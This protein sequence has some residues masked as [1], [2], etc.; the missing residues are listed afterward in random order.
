[1][2]AV[3]V[4]SRL[5]EEVDDV[6]TPLDLGSYCFVILM[7]TFWSGSVCFLLCISLFFR[8]KFLKLGRAMFL[9]PEIG[10]SETPMFDEGIIFCCQLYFY[11]K[12]S[13]SRIA[14]TP[15]AADG[16]NDSFETVKPGLTRKHARTFWWWQVGLGG[17][18]YVQNLS[19][20]YSLSHGQSFVGQRFLQP[21]MDPDSNDAIFFII[22]LGCFQIMWQINLPTNES[23]FTACLIREWYFGFQ[24]MLQPALMSKHFMIK[25]AERKW[26]GCHAWG[27]THALHRAVTWPAQGTLIHTKTIMCISLEPEISIDRWFFQLDDSKSLWWKNGWKKTPLYIHLKLVVLFQGTRYT[28]ISQDIPIVMVSRC[29]KSLLRGTKCH[30]WHLAMLAQGSF[31]DQVTCA[32]LQ[33]GQSVQ[34]ILGINPIRD[35]F[36]SSEWRKILSSCKSFHQGLLQVIWSNIF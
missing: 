10:P 9:L 2:R 32:P 8:M 4:A 31:G 19:K 16:K 20:S 22:L 35:R 15:Q 11:A 24:S 1:M 12:G 23:G 5:S 6:R 36:L 29:L 25:V 21:E 30:P 33:Q 34:S 26:I 7:V 18:P 17:N 27:N 14:P 13:G 3:Q 28:K